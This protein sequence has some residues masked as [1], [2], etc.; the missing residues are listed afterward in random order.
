MAAVAFSPDGKTLVGGNDDNNVYLWDVASGQKI[1]NVF[2]NNY[3]G[4]SSVAFSP[5]GKTIAVTNGDNG[6]VLLLDVAS[7][8]AG[9][10]LVTSDQTFVEHIA[11]SQDGK[12]IAGNDANN[13]VIWNAA[14]G[15][16]V[17]TF[18]GPNNH[19]NGV[20]FSPDSQTLA[21]AYSENNI[22]L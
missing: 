19:A 18:Q 6:G 9:K 1:R 3:N 22:H 2:T 10:T 17:K 7:G 12:M 15:Q 21:V 13:S 4:V 5:D 14:T 20:A 11:W 16:L 8:Q